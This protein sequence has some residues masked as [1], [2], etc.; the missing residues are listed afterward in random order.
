MNWFITTRHLA[1]NLDR[2]ISVRFNTD[3]G[4]PTEAELEIID[5][6]SMRGPNIILLNED[7]QKLFNELSAH[8]PEV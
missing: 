7:A 5:H 3:N 4:R 8:A 2:V 1:I 6:T